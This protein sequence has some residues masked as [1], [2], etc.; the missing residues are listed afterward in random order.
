MVGGLHGSKTFVAGGHVWLGDVWQGGM[1]GMAG[2][3]HGRWCV[4][5]DA[6]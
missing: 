1:H 6:W 5:R 4:W 3:V 2:G